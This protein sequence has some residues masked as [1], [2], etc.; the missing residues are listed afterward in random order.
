MATTF[1]PRL[2]S[3]DMSPAFYDSTYQVDPR[4]QT[5]P[6]NATGPD[7]ANPYN[8]NTGTAIIKQSAYLWG[9]WHEAAIYAS[10]LTKWDCNTGLGEVRRTR[11]S[12]SSITYL[13]NDYR[14]WYNA[15]M[16]N[17]SVYT[18]QSLGSMGSVI[19]GPEV[20]DL[21]Y[22]YDQNQSRW[23]AGVCER[24]LH[25][26]G[27]VIDSYLISL[28]S[29]TENRVIT[30]VINNHTTASGIPELG[31]NTD[32]AT[33]YG[34]GMAP[35]VPAKPIGYK[36]PIWMYKKYLDRQKGLI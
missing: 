23:Y 12:D 22:F 27:G 7:M 1:R 36:V 30:A 20:G 21:C 24:I 11:I 18:Y 17:T 15:S 31:V 26:S 13:R 14:W 8:I 34:G 5:D 28:W 29:P 32:Y 6:T 3:K 4:W 35:L 25:T 19:G 16:Y 9:R 33:W 2:N 10:G